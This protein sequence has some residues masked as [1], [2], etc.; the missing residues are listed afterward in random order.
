MNKSGEKQVEKVV[1]E[2]TWLEV[3]QIREVAMYTGTNVKA[4]K[5]EIAGKVKAM[6]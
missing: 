3:G 5:W 6:M 4:R 1:A 2:P